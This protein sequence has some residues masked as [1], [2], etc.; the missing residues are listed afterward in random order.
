MNPWD[1]Y[2]DRQLISLAKKSSQ[3]KKDRI[4]T[5]LFRRGYKY[6]ELLNILES[7]E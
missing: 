7:E 3:F 4:V 2:T 6:S 1:R 5:E